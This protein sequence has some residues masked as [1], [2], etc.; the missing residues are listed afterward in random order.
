MLNLSLLAKEMGRE[1]VEENRC[2]RE[3]GKILSG[4]GTF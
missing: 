1:I 2:R 3:I 4:Q